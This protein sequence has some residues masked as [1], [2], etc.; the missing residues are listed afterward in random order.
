MKFIHQYALR[1]HRVVTS[2]SV[3]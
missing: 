2:L 1:R 3:V